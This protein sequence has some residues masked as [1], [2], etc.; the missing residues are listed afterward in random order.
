MRL[1]AEKWPFQTLSEDANHGL[2][3]DLSGLVTTAR[4]WLTSRGFMTVDGP[5]TGVG[6]G[7]GGDSGRVG[8]GWRKAVVARTHAAMCA[9]A[10]LKSGW[11][12]GHQIMGAAEQVSTREA[13]FCCWFRNTLE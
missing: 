7:T 3:P 6:N 1:G 4:Q 10:L 13:S 8:V 12:S 9:S 11:G 2:E 5:L